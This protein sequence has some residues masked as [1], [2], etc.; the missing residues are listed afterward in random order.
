L[1]A[2]N[3]ISKDYNLINLYI[4]NIDTKIIFYNNI[5]LFNLIVNFKIIYNK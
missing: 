1:L 5:N 2:T 3:L 4:V